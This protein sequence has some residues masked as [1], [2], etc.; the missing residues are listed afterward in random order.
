MSAYASNSYEV[1]FDI[2]NRNKLIQELNNNMSLPGF[3]DAAEK[4]TK[5]VKQLKHL[6]S[7]TEPWQMSF[8][9]RAEI[10]YEVHLVRSYT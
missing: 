7:I 6:K 8:W 5:V 10:H 4:S 1:I 9:Q 3:W 2:D